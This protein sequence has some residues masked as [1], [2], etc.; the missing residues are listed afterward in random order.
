MNETIKTAIGGIV[1]VAMLV[2]FGFGAGYIYRGNYNVSLGEACW[3]TITDVQ[4]EY[5]FQEDKRRKI[6][7][8]EP[9]EDIYKQDVIHPCVGYQPWEDSDITY[10]RAMTR[11]ELNT[12]V[13]KSLEKPKP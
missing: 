8:G 5:W 11:D 4:F 6:E 10:Y 7:A 3:N 12:E 1:T 13:L 2:G 9:L